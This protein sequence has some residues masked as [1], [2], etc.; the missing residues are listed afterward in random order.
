M[1]LLTGK[2]ALIT[3]VANDYSIAWAIARALHAQGAELAFTYQNERLKEKMG[4]LVQQFKPK[5]LTELDVTKDEDIARVGRQVLDT[6]GRLDIFLHSLAFTPKED[7]HGDFYKTSRQGFAVSNDISSY[8]L[9][10]LSNALL[11]AFEAAGG[12]S[13]LYM[14]Y[15]GGEYAISTYRLAGVSKAAL[16]MSGKYLAQALGPK[17]IRVNGISAGPIKTLAARGIKN[18]SDLQKRAAEFMPLQGEIT[19]DDVAGTAVYLASDLSSAV[20]GEVIHVDKGFHCV[21]G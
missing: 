9:I 3:G 1:K 17:N 20:T 14:T 18:F 16:E 8:S 13:I 7:L 2:T 12:G 19:A 15:I 4:A 6:Y 10:A 5:L 21:R 11:P